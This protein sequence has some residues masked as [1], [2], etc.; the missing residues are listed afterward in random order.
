LKQLSNGLPCKQL[1]PCSSVSK[2]EPCTTCEYSV[3]ETSKK[4]NT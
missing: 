4:W 2:V 3:L 1:Q